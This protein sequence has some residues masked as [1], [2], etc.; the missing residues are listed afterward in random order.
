MARVILMDI[1]FDES[2]NA[3]FK[4]PRPRG[5]SHEKRSGLV[6]KLTPKAVLFFDDAVGAEAFI[7]RSVILDWWFTSCGTKRGLRV[8]DLERN[9]EITVFIPK[10]LVRKEQI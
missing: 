1:F 7:P 10:W 4:P 8:Q 9:D 6:V 5:S 3:S 2:G